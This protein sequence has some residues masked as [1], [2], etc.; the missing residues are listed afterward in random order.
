[1]LSTAR[2]CYI[3]IMK[4]YMFLAPVV[5]VGMLQ[6][7]GCGTTAVE[8]AVPGG[9]YI[10][11]SA[12]AHFDQAVGIEASAQTDDGEVDIASFNLQGSYR[13]T[14]DTN[15][16]FIAA[17]GNGVVVSGDGG[18]SWKIWGTPLVSV[19][20]VV[21]LSNGVVVVSGLDSE[22]QG[23][24]LRSI[25]QG[26]S[27]ETVLTIPMPVKTGGFGFLSGSSSGTGQ[28]VVISIAVD[29]LNEDRIY[30][31]TSLG[32]VLLGEQ[33][34]KTWQTLYT[35]TNKLLAYEGDRVQFAI[36]DLIASPHVSQEVMIVT[37]NG[38][39]YRI[40][41]GGQARVDVPQDLDN[42]SLFG[43]QGGRRE[44]KSLSYIADFPEALLV[45]VNDGA[46]VTRDGGETWRQL[47]LPVDTVQEF[48][49]VVVQ[50]SP[51]NSARMLV[52][53]NSVVYRSEDGGVT[54]SAFSMGL[55]S[56]MITSIMIDPKNAA[57]VLV[58]TTP[59]GV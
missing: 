38:D 35:L 20:D 21:A 49:T 12:G 46:V 41:E 36:R 30:A 48:N 43:G 39:L 58:V 40:N 18:N 57:N 2:L 14:F 59:I 37:S 25:D 47:S 19:S 13:P 23:Y 9:T 33:S 22:G 6:A 29:P 42:E 31:G 34:G 52:G 7:G 28:S 8:K 4:I 55:K 51:T 11:T 27:W 16:V 17:G 44:I 1:V 26:K 15:K 45:G 5:V 54:W 10:S 53:I 56:H 3:E 50:V 24:I 32:N